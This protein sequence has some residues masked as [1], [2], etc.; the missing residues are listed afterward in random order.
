MLD[1]IA[2][3]LE[4]TTLSQALRSSIW[5]Y[6]LVSTGHVIGIAL[7]LGGIAPLDLRL[8]GCW[9][10]VAI[11]PLV[12]ILVPMAISGLVLAVLTG[13]LLF[14]TRPLDYVNEPLFGIKMALLV[15][16]VLNALA[17]RR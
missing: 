13:S 1:A 4:A 3:A 15:M 5:L 2:G 6:P 12:R 7:L 16:A 8:I 11:A 10:S 9:R 14:A 17:L